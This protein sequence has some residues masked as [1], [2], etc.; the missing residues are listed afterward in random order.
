MVNGDAASLVLFGSLFVLVLDGMSS[1]DAKRK[2]ACGEDWER[3]AA[4]PVAYAAFMH[5]HK[6]SFGVSPRRRMATT[7][8]QDISG[9]W[10][11]GVRLPSP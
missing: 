8:R 6:A 9:L 5:F 10:F 3:F 7:L 11:I 2:K 4:A 1:I